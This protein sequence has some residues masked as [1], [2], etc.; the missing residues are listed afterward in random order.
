MS[1]S[2]AKRGR[3]DGDAAV[4]Q[5]R[6]DRPKRPRLSLVGPS[7][8]WSVQA[9]LG[10]RCAAGGATPRTS[11][12]TPATPRGYGD[13]DAHA[14]T[15][16]PSS[17]AAGVPATPAAEPC[18]GSESDAQSAARGQ[19][20]ARARKLKRVSWSEELD[21]VFLITPRSTPRATA[22]ACEA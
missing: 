7:P 11:A 1:V 20:K 21:T 17:G 10:M 4:A 18:G 9:V 13:L 15:V 16:S 12:R 22:V 2:T 19:N 8:S 14:A 6:R 5:Q 3:G